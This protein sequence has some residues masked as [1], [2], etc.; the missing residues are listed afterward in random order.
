MYQNGADYRRAV[1]QVQYLQGDRVFIRSC[2]Y[3]LCCTKIFSQKHVIHAS[4]FTSHLSQQ[5]YSCLA[6]YFQAHA[7][8]RAASANGL[9]PVMDRAGGRDTK[10]VTAL[11]HP[12][13]TPRKQV[14]SL[15]MIIEEI[16]R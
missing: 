12:L 4:S 3:F 9:T 8:L 6:L 16:T 14:K 13:I 15:V 7:H 5:Y 1:F 2:V 10:P 11:S